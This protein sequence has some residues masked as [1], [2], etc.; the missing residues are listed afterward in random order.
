MP[1]IY[2]AV[3]FGLTAWKTAHVLKLRTRRK[4]NGTSGDWIM[5]V[6][7]RDGSLYFLC[8]QTPHTIRESPR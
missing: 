1:V 4:S 5:R 7:L 3:I 2:D 8:A 6:L